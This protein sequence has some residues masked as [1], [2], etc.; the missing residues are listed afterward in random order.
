MGKRLCDML[1][2]LWVCVSVPADTC[3]CQRKSISENELNR[4]PL[5]CYRLCRV[6]VYHWCE[7]QEALAH[8]LSCLWQWT[9]SAPMPL[10]GDCQVSHLKWFC[11]KEFKLAAAICSHGALMPAPYH[12]WCKTKPTEIHRDH[13]HFWSMYPDV[14]WVHSVR[15]DQPREFLRYQSPFL[16]FFLEVLLSYMPQCYST[17]CDAGLLK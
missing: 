6:L 4:C 17:C 12:F 13:L 14:H 5:L 16:N 1:Y 10:N 3:Y 9:L 8:G 15:C 7:G 2:V 11:V